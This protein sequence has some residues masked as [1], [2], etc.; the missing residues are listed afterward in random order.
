MNSSPA[1]HPAELVQGLR[2]G[3][4]WSTV[5]QPTGSTVVFGALLALV[6]CF[7]AEVTWSVTY[8]PRCD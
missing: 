4:A 3:E 2:T 5:L 6:D 1:R 7:V 8:G